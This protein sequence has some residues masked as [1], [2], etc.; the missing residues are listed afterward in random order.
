MLGDDTAEMHLEHQQRGEGQGVLPEISSGDLHW[1]QMHRKICS[2][3]VICGTG[4]LPESLK[5]N[6]K[7]NKKFQVQL[8]PESVKVQ[9]GE[10]VS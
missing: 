10:R 7:Q 3:T 4:D 9:Q 8:E 5:K 6:Q 1:L 2:K